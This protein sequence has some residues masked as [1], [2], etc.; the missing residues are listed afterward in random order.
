MEERTL[1]LNRPIHIQLFAKMDR[2]LRLGGALY[3]DFR[4]SGH[5]GLECHDV[6]ARAGLGD[7][8]GRVTRRRRHELRGSPTQVVEPCL[9]VSTWG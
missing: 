3:T 8:D 6:H 5:D 4:L 9:V 2:Y 7:R 1:V